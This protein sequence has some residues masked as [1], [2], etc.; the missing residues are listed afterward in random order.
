VIKNIK[1]LLKLKNKKTS[2]QTKK[3]AKNLN[4]HLIKE[5][6]QME[7]K[8]LKR[9]SSSYVIWERQ[10]KEII[11]YH[12]YL[13]QWSKSVTLTTTNTTKDMNQ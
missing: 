6:I 10:V 7:N 3:W 9:Y 4:G 5:D 13:L 12:P 11:R 1:E 8:H 2:N